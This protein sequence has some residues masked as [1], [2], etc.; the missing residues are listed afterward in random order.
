MGKSI[1]HSVKII[2]AITIIMASLVSVCHAQDYNTID[3]LKSKIS[4][5]EEK[6]LALLYNSLG[7]EYRLANPD[8]TLYYCRKA[9][10]IAIDYDLLSE[11]SKSMN[12]IGIAFSYKGEYKESF[13]YYERAIEIS[14]ESNDSLQL[15]HS[16]NNMGR[17]FFAQADIV[18]SYDYFFNA[19]SIFKK[20]NNLS[21]LAYCY[22][23]LVLVYEAQNNYTKAL[24][25]AQKALS[26]RIDSNNKRGQI[27]T[28]KDLAR[29]LM[30]LD[31]HFEAVEN[32]N[33]AIAIAVKLKDKIS[34]SEINLGISKV[35]YQLKDY[36]LALEYCNAALTPIQAFRNQNLWVEINQQLG[37]IFYA[38][39]S[40]NTAEKHLNEV[41]VQSN[42]SGRIEPLKEAYY[43][44]SLIAVKK[45]N[46]KQALNYYQLHS[47]IKDSL[48][49]TDI[50]RTIE[51]MESRIEIDITQKE[52]E[53][54]KAKEEKNQL[55]IA[56]EKNK[57][58]AL[59]IIIA[60]AFITVV[61]LSVYLRQKIKHEKILTL[62]KEK[63]EDQNQKINEQNYNLEKRNHELSD[64]G[65]EKDNLMNIVAHD[66]KSPFN[67]LKGLCQL[68]ELTGSLNNEQQKYIKIMKEVSEKGANLTRDILDVN[69]FNSDSEPLTISTLKAIDFLNE[70]ANSFKSE[71]AIKQIV[72]NVT[73]TDKA[74]TFDCEESYL[75]RIMD[76]LL[77]NAIKYSSEETTI[78]LKA[79]AIENT[80]QLSVIDQ[81]P[82]FNEEDKKHAFK[83]F[84][85]LSARPTGGE[86]SNG[87]GL[88]IVKTLVSRL[89]GD[90]KLNSEVG[91]GSE[92]IITFPKLSAKE[93]ITRI[94]Q[95]KASTNKSA[96]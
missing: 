34:Q 75:S 18:K 81:G 5:T 23:S 3:S 47:A 53:L 2:Y 73:E 46:N 20:Q 86:S 58:L 80:I 8:S 51:R 29:I 41:V 67:N 6:E 62:Q 25:I 49:S 13:Q 43:Y 50:A 61:L 52:N 17:L 84:Q 76:N 65:I 82:G 26:I 89:G 92:F 33:A 88:A 66:L 63:I 24:E 1:I 35:H 71:A 87:L 56:K 16:Y 78:S 95:D 10:S 83:K 28:Y 64:L 79:A 36:D 68:V 30:S 42:I 69:A 74:M 59:T 27:S 22:Q 39:K 57:N 21:G 7:W 54:L 90:I 91:Q 19:L 85:R 77:S 45:E 44:L 93:K 38:K 11:L 96:T 14:I 31:R 37:K 72:I 94:G 15:G 12:F 70:K 60:L 55:F 9:S 40:L 4:S 48:Y 32:L